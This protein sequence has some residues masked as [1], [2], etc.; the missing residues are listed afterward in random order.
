MV[1]GE[2][3]FLHAL[4]DERADLLGVGRGAEH[5]Q[6]PLLEI[7]QPGLQVSHGV[8]LGFVADADLVADQE[9]RDL[10][11]EFLAGVLG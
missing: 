3:A 5:L 1:F 7:G 8:A 6:R 2:A 4:V 11:A 9:A 10:G